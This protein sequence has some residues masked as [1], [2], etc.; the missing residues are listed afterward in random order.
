[1]QNDTLTELDYAAIGR[2]LNVYIKAKGLTVSEVA[3]VLQVSVPTVSKTVNGHRFS[4]EMLIKLQAAYP[5]LRLP[6]L[7][8]GQGA[9]EDYQRQLAHTYQE[10]LHELRTHYQQLHSLPPPTTDGQA[11]DRVAALCKLIDDALDVRMHLLSEQLD[12]QHLMLT[13]LNHG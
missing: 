10:Q 9:M 13:H 1:M 2:R 5:N 6:W 4:A 12:A 8:L 11:K 7:L 3:G